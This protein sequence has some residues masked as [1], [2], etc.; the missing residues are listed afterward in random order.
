MVCK[1]CHKELTSTN[2]YPAD[3]RYCIMCGTERTAYLSER[4]QTLT[5]LREMNLESKI[6]QTKYLIK[7]A[8][9]E[10]G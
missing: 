5:S 8:V 2:V 9:M 1:K 7:C 6:I 4:R 3:Y 10:F